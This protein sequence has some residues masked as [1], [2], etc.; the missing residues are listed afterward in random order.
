MCLGDGA[1]PS[2]LRIV[3]ALAAGVLQSLDLGIKGISTS[4]TLTIGVMMLVPERAC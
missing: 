3:S 2:R 4:T 1:L